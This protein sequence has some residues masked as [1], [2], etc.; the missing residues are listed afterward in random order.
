MAGGLFG[1]PFSINLKCYFFT[2]CNGTILYK[3]EFKSNIS[4]YLTL[5]VIFGSLCSYGGTII[6]LIVR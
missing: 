4:L 3:P 2:Y 6:I 1:K 5:L